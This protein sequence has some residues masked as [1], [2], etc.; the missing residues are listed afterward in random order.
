MHT[1]TN[2]DLGTHEMSHLGTHKVRR[3]HLSAHKTSAP[4]GSA[5]RHLCSTVPSCPPGR[6]AGVLL[7]EVVGRRDEDLP[8]QA[9]GGEDHVVGQVAPHLRE[10]ERSDVANARACMILHACVYNSVYVYYCVR[11][12]CCANAANVDV[13]LHTC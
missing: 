7:V 10:R 5:S 12:R 4:Q 11:I 13:L 9:G 1:Q 2:I 8:D 3:R 6:I